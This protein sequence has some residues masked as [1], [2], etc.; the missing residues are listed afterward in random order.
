MADCVVNG[1]S[2]IASSQASSNFAGILAGFLF[3]GLIYLL[4]RDEKRGEI[5]LLFTASF[6]VL[7]F[8]GYLFSRVSGFSAPSDP[9]PAAASFCK[10]VWMVGMISYAMLIAGTTSMIVGLGY[11]LVS[12]DPRSERTHLRRLATVATAGILVG[13]IVILFTSL[14]YYDELLD[15]PNRH[16]IWEWSSLA[17]VV[18]LAFS[19][20]TFFSSRGPGGR[21]K[22]RD[23]YLDCAV[24]VVGG[25]GIAG[26]ALTGIATRVNP[27]HWISWLAII[28]SLG[29]PA[30]IVVLLAGGTVDGKD[31]KARFREEE[32]ALALDVE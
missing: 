1:W 17:I 9:G 20:V 10:G 25:F 18:V 15:R 29:F 4:G 27:S 23:N 12:Y 28:V 6:I 13:S 5:V 32:E 2:I 14:N 19:C 22:V 21:R 31:E 8:A 24:Y 3:F 16:R 30:I 11:V 7:A 26:T